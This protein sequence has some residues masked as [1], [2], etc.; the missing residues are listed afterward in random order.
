M[1]FRIALLMLFLGGCTMFRPVGD[2]AAQHL[3]EPLAPDR[4]LGATTPAVA[5]NRA[6]LP[7]YLDG[8]ELVTRRDGI[9][10]ASKHDL[11]AEALDVGISRVMAEN[12]GRLTGSMNIQP[13]ES[14]NTLDYTDLLEL[15]ITRFEPDASNTM[16]L[17]GTW[18]LQPVTGKL[19]RNHFFRIAVPLTSSPTVMKDRVTA[20]NEALVKL[21][22]EIAAGM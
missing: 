15:R 8:Q 1:N 22:R 5:V 16:V 9:L 17:Q 13:V 20:M 19:G 7:G 3:L 11:W 18:K 4:S 10:V 21:A 6:T 2:T 12:L 14:F